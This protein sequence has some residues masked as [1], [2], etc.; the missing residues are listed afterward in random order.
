MPQEWAL[1]RGTFDWGVLEEKSITHRQTSK[2]PN[3]ISVLPVSYC[4]IIVPVPV[5]Y[6]ETEA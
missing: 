2:G 3:G 4:V 1:V 5:A 6:V